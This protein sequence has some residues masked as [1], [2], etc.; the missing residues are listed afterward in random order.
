M[1]NLFSFSRYQTKCVIMFLFGRLIALQTLRFIFDQ[2]LKQRLT[3]EKEGKMETQKFQ[4]LENGE[5][6]LDEIKSI[7]HNF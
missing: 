7:F 6:L 4:Y 2:S 1:S 3:E 5:S